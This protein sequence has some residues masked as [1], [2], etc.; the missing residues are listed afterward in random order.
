[1]SVNSSYL[2][3]DQGGQSSRV[4]LFDGAGKLLQ[5]SQRQVASSRPQPGWVEQDPQSLLTSLQQ[6]LAEIELSSNENISAALVTQRSSLLCWDRI[7][8]KPLSPILS[9]QDTR[10]SSDLEQL[11][12]DQSYT[13][14][15]TGLFPSAHFGASKIRWCL[16]H[17]PSVAEAAAQQRLCIAPLSSFLLFHLLSNRPYKVDATN[18]QRTMLYN[19]GNGQWDSELL[20]QF[21][22]PEQLLPTIENNLCHWGHLPV[23]GQEVPVALVSGDQSAAFSALAANRDDVVVANIGTGAFIGMPLRTGQKA[24]PK[25]LNT[26]LL[27]G[28]QGDQFIAEGTVN[29]A[30]SALQNIAEQLGTDASL[31]FDVN[32]GV[33]NQLPLFL[34]GVGGLAAPFWQPDFRSRFV[35]DGSAQQKLQAVL[36]SIA[37]LLYSNFRQIQSLGNSITT[38][39]V[40]GGLAQSERLCTLLADLCQLPVHRSRLS[41]ST[42]YGAAWLLAGKPTWQQAEEVFQPD[43]QNKT[44]ANRYASWITA[45]QHN[46]QL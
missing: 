10:A 15:Q 42:A 29:G 12:L 35:G 1:M 9:W 39:T 8:G 40:G 44:I 31:A 34:N 22:I 13:R 3:L 37:F 28:Q 19:I 30:G 14:T 20:Q 23:A 5:L 24:P 27:S 7:T 21:D 11:Q 4:A 33:S 43:R 41:E 2:V 25:L 38:L 32:Q 45:M 6:C 16:Q 36:E 46:I 17:I 18:A 26:L